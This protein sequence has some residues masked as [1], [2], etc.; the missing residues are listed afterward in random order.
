MLAPVSIGG[1]LAI[2]ARLVATVLLIALRLATIAVVAPTA[3]RWR[4]H[5]RLTL[6]LHPIATV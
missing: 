1:G 5:W 3:C 4:L 2:V 6:L